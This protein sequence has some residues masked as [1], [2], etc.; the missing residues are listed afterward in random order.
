[1]IDK[2]ARRAAQLAEIFKAQRPAY[3]ERIR[4]WCPHIVE[5][6]PDAAWMTVPAD[7]RWRHLLAITDHY[8]CDPR[9][10]DLVAFS[11]EES[12]EEFRRRW[13]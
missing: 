1:M 7:D 6:E 3:I 11:M 4:G 12:A 10:P 9:Y 13:A 5:V 2:I 8:S